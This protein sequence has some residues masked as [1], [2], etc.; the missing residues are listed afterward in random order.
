VPKLQTY[1]I[2][3][4]T[5]SAKFNLDH[6][7]GA[8]LT[9][10]MVSFVNG[11]SNA[12]YRVPFRVPIA[13]TDRYEG[14]MKL[15]G[16][17]DEWT[18]AEAIQEGSLVLMMSRPALQDAR[19]ELASHP[20][21]IYSCWGSQNF[22]LGFQLEGLSSALR[23]AHNDVHYQARRAWDEDLAEVLVQPI[24]ADDTTGPV[25]HIV[26]KPNGAVWLERKERDGAREAWESVE[27]AGLRYAT[28]NTVEGIWRG[29]AGIPW[30]VI[31]GGDRPIPALLRFNFTQHRNSDCESASWCGPVDYGRDDQLTGLLYVR[32]PSSR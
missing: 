3:P 10:L 5:I 11:Y 17:L 2:E 32:T 26:F 22:Y 1:H 21:R 27:G 24:F 7:N 9:P 20:A 14:P 23:E 15:D 28:T 19:L 31:S 16:R 12:A 4:A 29:E 25:T 18:E 6:I 30:R 8:A 13:A